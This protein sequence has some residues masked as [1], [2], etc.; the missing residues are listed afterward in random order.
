VSG[1]GKHTPGPWVAE[2]DGYSVVT[3]ATVAAN[4]V[5]GYG[6][7]PDFVCS[8]NDGE[9][10]EYSDAAEQLANARL[11]SA[12][13]DLLAVAR[14]WIEYLDADEAGDGRTEELLL[15]AIRA[16]I[17]KAESP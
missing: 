16:A 6:S 4:R 13:P 12:A 15:H 9:Y 1:A 14:A 8:L 2:K 5:H 7:G 11:I 3:T 10:H 17:S